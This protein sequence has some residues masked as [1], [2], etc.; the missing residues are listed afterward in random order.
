MPAPPP[1]SSGSNSG[2]FWGTVTA[3]GVVAGAT[4]VLAAAT[5]MAVTGKGCKSAAK[6]AWEAF[7]KAVSGGGGAGA[8]QA[9]TG[10]GFNTF[11]QLKK[12]LGPAGPGRHWHHIVEQ[13]QILRSGF[14]QT[15]I[16]N[17]NNIVNLTTKQH[18]FV[19]GQFNRFNHNLGMTLRD[20]L[21]GQPFDVQFE[22]GMRIVEEAIRRFPN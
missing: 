9:A 3:I 14:C 10:Q 6:Q 11:Y 8:G 7:K 17:V 20:W 13:S 5:Y 16:H 12:F 19:T 15:I 18:Q 1:T 2:G 4:A 21:T 22:E